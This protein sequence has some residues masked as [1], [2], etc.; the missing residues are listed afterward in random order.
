MPPARNR[1]G[2]VP[3]FRT[4]TQTPDR[5]DRTCISAGRDLTDLRNLPFSEFARCVADLL[6]QMGYEDVHLAGRA[7]LRR[8]NGTCG[9]DLVAFVPLPLPGFPRRQQRLKV[10]VLLKQFRRDDR[11]FQRMVDELRGVALRE[12]ADEAI[13]IT[14]G[15]LS[16]VIAACE[17]RCEDGEEAGGRKANTGGRTGKGIASPQ[18]LLFPPIHRIDG[19]QLCRLLADYR[20]TLPGKP[21]RSCPVTRKASSSTDSIPPIEGKTGI[22]GSR[23]DPGGEPDRNTAEIHLRIRLMSST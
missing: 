12:G 17:G 22:P 8:Q 13:L 9:Y 2:K 21:V 23:R 19:E 18:R 10:I 7:D 6:N 14:T 4:R 5:K 20:V 3:C 16:G 1:S 15:R 11:V